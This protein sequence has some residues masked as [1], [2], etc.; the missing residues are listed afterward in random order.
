MRKDALENR[1]KIE[2]KAVKLFNTYGVESVSMN[3]ISQELNI[4]MGTLYRN[5]SDKAALCYQLIE[6]D[7]V[8][9]FEQ[10]D[11]VQQNRQISGNDKR[12]FYIDH[13]LEFKEKHIEM[14]NCI[15]QQEQKSDFRSSE[16]YQKL[17]H[18][19]CNLYDATDELRVFKADMLLNA[20]TT[21]SYHYQKEQRR[22]SNETFRMYLIT[23]FS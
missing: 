21:H 11:V 2:E 23:L 16:M 4:G 10:F 22:L 1:R 14:L 9:L 20:M 8:L 17:H 15:E 18:Y 7:F 5:F 12:I 6:N 13:F 3:R 19:F